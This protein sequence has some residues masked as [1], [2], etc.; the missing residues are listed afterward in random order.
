VVASTPRERDIVD[1]LASNILGVAATR[2][3]S[4]IYASLGFQKPE[5]YFEPCESVEFGGVLFLL[6]FLLANGLLSYKKI[7][8]KEAIGIL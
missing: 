8:F 2:I 6:P 5:I 3:E 4:R 1:F 7:L